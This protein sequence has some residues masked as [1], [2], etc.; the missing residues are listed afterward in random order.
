MD[1]R[2][3]MP[4][5]DHDLGP[6]QDQET[7]RLSDLLRAQRDTILG[8]WEH[9]VRELRP[10]KRLPHPVLMDHMPDLL[11][12]I[13]AM[14]DQLATG[15]TPTVSRETAES[16]AYARLEVGY[17]L[18]EVVAEYAVLRDTIL[19]HLAKEQPLALQEELRVVHRAIDRAVTAS[20]ERYTQA[21]ERTL[22]GLNRIATASFESRSLEDLLDRLLRAFIETTPAADTAAILLREGA[23][24]RVRATAGLEEE[25]DDQEFSLAIGEGFAG[26]IAAE[27][28]PLQLRSAATDPQ[29]KSPVIRQR[30]V[31]ALYGVPLMEQD[32]LV[33]VAYMG[34]LTAYEFS[35]EDQRLF[36][37]LARRATSAIAYHLLRQQLEQKNALLSAMVDQL[38]AGVI[39]AESPSGRLLLG[40]EQ[41]AKIWR[42]PFIRS[43]SI[44]QYGAWKGFDPKDGRPLKPEE[45][46]LARAL[47]HGETVLDQEVR[48]LRGDGTWGVVLNNAAPVRDSEGR[49]IAG[50]VAFIDITE[51]KQDQERL[52]RLL[53]D[54][55]AERRRFLDLVHHLDRTVVWEADADTLALSFVSQRAQEL[56]GYPFEEWMRPPGFWEH[57]VPVEDREPLLAMLRRSVA[58]GQGRCEHR[59]LVQGGGV[60]WVQ[61]GVHLAHRNGRPLLQGATVDISE[62]R[63]ALEARDDVLAVVS[64]DLRSPLGAIML[65]ATTLLRSADAGEAGARFRRKCGLIVRSAERMTR[66]IDDLVDLASIRSG[67]LSITPR[68]EPVQEL[69]Q[70][71]VLGF[72]AIAEE[73]KVHLERRHGQGEAGG[74]AA[75]HLTV[76]C[77][78][79]RVLQVFSNL[80]GNAL[81]VTPPGGRIT[82]QTE[83]R[84]EDVVFS[85]TDTGPGIAPEELPYLFKRYWR[86]D[87][88]HYKGHGLGLAIAQGIVEAHGGRIGAESQP[89]K[90]STFFFTL[91]RAPVGSVGPE[92]ERASERA[93][94]RRSI[95]PCSSG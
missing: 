94:G 13:A 41:V 56:T 9:A 46:A 11:T 82:V 17:D 43:G 23:R 38:P 74:P 33:G 67:R 2:G 73:R 30:G 53:G 79:D 29:V 84:P 45:W 76:L 10:A 58:E 68:P 63:E 1:P 80:I 47:L 36:E 39:L 95:A 26:R 70:E 20:V 3:K 32:E 91:P 93:S 18:S 69:A 28:R 22:T 12:Q 14:A 42:H 75:A 44:E 57:L 7:F 65:N 62:L 8:D 51:R 31:R 92:G 34:S 88:V 86:S 35:Q 59:L 87:K 85:I 40:N 49:I 25:L 60:R 16:H 83:V 64:H 78:R 48:I 89:G 24:L 81:Q 54:L 37:V 15:R 52:V 6:R 5:Q 66:L 21:R 19:Q 71:A 61:T 90:G 77:D 55:D 50:I 4:P 27:R 72:E